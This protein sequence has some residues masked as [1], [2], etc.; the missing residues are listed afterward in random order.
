MNCPTFQEFKIDQEGGAFVQDRWT[1]NRL[2][3]N[4][5]LRLDWF[6]SSQPSYHLYPSM[7]TPLRNY[8]VPQDDT[9]RMKDWTPKLAASWDVF[10]DGKTA[11]KVN[12]SKD[13]LGL[14]LA[15]E[16]S[17]DYTQQ[18]Q[19]RDNGGLEHHGRSGKNLDRQQQQLHPGLRPHEPG[20][21]GPDPRWIPPDRWTP[22]VP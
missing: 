18:L 22:A 4:A 13:V 11:V 2:T 5:G 7:L 21:A 12:L 20:G 3:V 16:Q 1:I 17:A 8:D 14:S 19:H 9:V 15:G 6:N 10:G